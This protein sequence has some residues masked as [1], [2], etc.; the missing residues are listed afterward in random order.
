[1]N[2]K[3][4]Y[5]VTLLALFF[6]LNT[7]CSPDSVTSVKENTGNSKPELYQDKPVIIDVGNGKPGG[8]ISVK[9]NLDDG[10]NIK[11]SISGFTGAF[12]TGIS[13]FKVSLVT[14]NSGPLTTAPSGTPASDV[15][16]ITKATLSGTV[17]ASSAQI[18]ITNVPAGTFFVAVAAIDNAGKDET[19]NANTISTENYAVSSAS[20][21]VNSSF[22]PTPSTQLTVP[23]TLANSFGATLDSTV[24]VTPGTNALSTIVGFRFYLVNTNTGTLALPA[25]PAGNV[26]LGPFDATASINTTLFNALKTGTATTLHFTNV[27]ANTDISPNNRYFVAA[28]VWKGV[29]TNKNNNITNSAAPAI[30]SGGT[31]EGNYKASTTGGDTN[32][33]VT[34]ATDLTLTGTT[35]LGVALALQ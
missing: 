6:S 14:N 4:K 33:Q 12:N 23:L 17:T 9:V 2:L 28:S 5:I 34:V 3:A 8:S 11:N 18:L 27:P 32:G 25:S 15:K 13:S 26:K 30:G 24:T 1:L 19:T 35:N 10:F 7:A 22:T 16:I 31:A 29:F 20:V 21:T